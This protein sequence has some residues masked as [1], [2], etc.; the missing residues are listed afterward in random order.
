MSITEWQQ[1]FLA[2]KLAQH[3]IGGEIEYKYPHNLEGCRK[4][5]V[6]HWL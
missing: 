3:V 2:L 4:E 6:R 5:M 1:L